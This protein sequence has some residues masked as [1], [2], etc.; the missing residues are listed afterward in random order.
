M[1]NILTSQDIHKSNDTFRVRRQQRQGA[2]RKKESKLFFDP[3][4]PRIPP[5]KIKKNNIYN[6]RS[7]A[8]FIYLN[9]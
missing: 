5:K 4:L 1:H 6:C 2:H 9:V 3:P 7:Q 8:G